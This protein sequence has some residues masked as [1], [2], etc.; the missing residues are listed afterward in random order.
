MWSGKLADLPG[1]LKSGTFIKPTQSSGAKGAF[2]LFPDGGIFSVFSGQQLNSWED[3]VDAAR[4]QLKPNAPCEQ[5]WECQELVLGPDG[6][7]G[8]DMKFFMFYGEIGLIQE[9]SRHPKKEYEFFDED[10]TVAD[11]GRDRSYE[12]PF[13]NPKDTT[14][15]K[16]ALSEEKLE[17]VRRFSRELPVPFMR[18]DFLNGRDDLQ[19]LEF[20]SAPGM[21]H[22]FN[23]EYDRKLGRMYN[24]AMIRLTNDLLDGKDFSDFRSWAEG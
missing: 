2:Y 4:D 18:I 24:E 7:P 6:R 11:C 17:L 15:D 16:G 8:R 21:A 10:G 12:P 14:T 23:L 9:V 22:T 20:S 13:E 19:F 3:L 5:T 1:D